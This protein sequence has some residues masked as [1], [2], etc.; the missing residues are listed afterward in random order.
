MQLDTYVLKGDSVR[1]AVCSCI[2]RAHTHR[3]KHTQTNRERHDARRRALLFGGGKSQARGSRPR[4]GEG[5][6]PNCRH[7]RPPSSTRAGG[8]RHAPQTAKP[9]WPRKVCP[10]DP[11]PGR[12][13]NAT[14][15]KPPTR[16]LSRAENPQACVFACRP[17]PSQPPRV[18]LGLPLEELPPPCGKPLPRKAADR[19]LRT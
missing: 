7:R 12:H 11:A 4:S 17:G 8:P 6:R 10:T 1:G 18:L 19:E 13:T 14:Q 16:D 2:A 9:A 15:G 5:I 3:H